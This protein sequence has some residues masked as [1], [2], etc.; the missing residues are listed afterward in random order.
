MADVE[1]STLGSVIKT[2][3]EG[4]TNTNAYTDSEKT[5]LGNIEANA[6]TD[7]TGFEIKTAY[8]SQADTNA[9]TD[10]EKNKLAGIETAATADQTGAEIKTA[11]ES[12]AN[13]NAFTDAEKTKLSGVATGAEVN[14]I[15][16][17]PTSDGVTGSDQVTNVV[18]CTQ[19]EYDAGTP[20]ASTFYLITDAV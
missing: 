4:E 11:Y 17:D 15:D 9:Y 12:Q 6:T 19:A 8:E 10:S 7:Q 5:K 20:N 18:S 3:Y 14:T 2:A 16:S 1:L 13:T